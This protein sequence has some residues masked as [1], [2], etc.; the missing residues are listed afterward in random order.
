MIDVKKEAERIIL[1]RESWPV[2]EMVEAIES[3][4][5]RAV[6]EATGPLVEGLRDIMHGAC[7]GASVKDFYNKAAEAL[8]AHRKDGGEKDAEIAKRSLN[9]GPTQKR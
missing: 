4:V 7:Y 3:L 9:N 8:S 1:I 6:E 5:T 2:T